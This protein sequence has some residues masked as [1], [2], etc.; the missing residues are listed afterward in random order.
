[1]L[2]NKRV[3]PE[4]SVFFCC[5]IQASSAAHEINYPTM[6]KNAARLAQTAELLQIPVIAT[7]HIKFGPIDEEVSSKFYSGVT[8]FED[9]R[10]FSMID[11]R[12]SAHLSSLPQERKCAVLYGCDAHVCVKQT[13]FDLLELGH[14]V[15]IVVDATTS[16][17]VSDRNVGI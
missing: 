11:E 4:S 2:A 16:M 13:A 6:T 14:T 9:K 7:S 3:T 17:I 8:V 5:D 15:F 1:M 10:C 12:V